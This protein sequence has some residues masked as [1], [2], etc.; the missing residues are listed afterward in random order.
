M[1]T[2]LD[3]SYAFYL[4]AKLKKRMQFLVLNHRL[5]KNYMPDKL[6]AIFADVVSQAEQEAGYKNTLKDLSK[7]AERNAEGAT[8]A[9]EGEIA[10]SYLKENINGDRRD[11]APKE[12]VSHGE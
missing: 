7:D 10:S 12:W 6:R 8:G 11:E 3:A 1:E 4:D 2:R 5:S 9:V